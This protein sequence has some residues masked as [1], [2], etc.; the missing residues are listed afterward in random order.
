MHSQAVNL[1]L[2][3]AEE[4]EKTSLHQIN[5]KFKYRMKT[6]KELVIMVLAH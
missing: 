5:L 3:N 6:K 1:I 2:L 4:A